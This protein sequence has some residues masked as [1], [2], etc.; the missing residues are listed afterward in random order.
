MAGH[1]PWREIKHKKDEQTQR[2][3]K[4]LEI[5]VPE[6]KSILDALRK[7]ARPAKKPSE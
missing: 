7:V 3:E 2:T 1:T 6:R 4:G 5:P